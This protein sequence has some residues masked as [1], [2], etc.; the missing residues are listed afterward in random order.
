MTSNTEVSIGLIIMD[1]G[2]LM[3]KLCDRRF[4]PIGLTR[5]QWQALVSIRRFGP[6]TQSA[7]ADAL[8]IESATA[9]RLIDRLET[10]GWVE[11]RSD[12]KD[13]R[14]KHVVL[15]DKSERIMG[16]ISSIGQKLREDIVTDLSAIEREQLINHLSA[17]KARLIHLL[18]AP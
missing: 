5:A 10:A 3:R 17:V 9:A 11:R 15:T 4:D 7:L 1:V 8:E 6:I 12:A 16:E 13:R 2:R 18:E 14:V